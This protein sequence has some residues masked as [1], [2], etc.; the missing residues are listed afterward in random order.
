[1]E[2]GLPKCWEATMTPNESRI[3]NEQTQKPNYI[4]GKFRLHFL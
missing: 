2:Y 1:M 4:V 3:V